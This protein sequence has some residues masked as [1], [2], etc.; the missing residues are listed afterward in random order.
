MSTSTTTE[1]VWEDP[2]AP[3]RRPSTDYAAMLAPF[4]DNP[5]RAGRFGSEYKTAATAAAV[6]TRLRKGETQGV[7]PDLFEF[8]SRK[9]EDGGGIVYCR[10]LGPKGDIEGIWERRSA[11]KSGDDGAPAAK[12]AAKSRRTAAA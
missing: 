12:P 8:T 9:T 10:Y 5:G 11:A 7:D 3:T 4:I 6:S 2:P 1:V